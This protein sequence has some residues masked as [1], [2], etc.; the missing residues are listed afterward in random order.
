MNIIFVSLYLYINT[1]QCN[2]T[3]IYFLHSCLI[4]LEAKKLIML[5]LLND[6]YNF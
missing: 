1:L 5:I 2:N 3:F 4:H 6:N